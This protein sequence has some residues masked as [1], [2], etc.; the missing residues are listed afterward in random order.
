MLALAGVCACG[1]VGFD[2]DTLAGPRLIEVLVDPVAKSDDPSL[3]GDLLELYFESERAGG[4]GGGD[5]WVS[6]RASPGAPWEPPSNVVELNTA[7]LE[8]TPKVSADGLRLWLSSDRPGTVGATDIFVSTRSSRTAPWGAPVH[9]PELSSTASD[10]SPSVSGDGLVIVFTSNRS[11]QTGFD[12][13]TSKRAQA[14]VPFAS[15][16]P[17]AELN[18]A[19]P[20]DA[21]PFLEPS[22]LFLWFNS[23]RPGGREPDIFMT[24][25]ASIAEPFAVPVPVPALMSEYREV[26]SCINLAAGYAVFASDRTGKLEIWEMPWP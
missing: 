12:L 13:Y 16:T 9:V 26:D 21:G 23:N 8:S 11:G 1:R 22:G 10:G 6:R 19:G 18:T 3:T 4:A 25:R 2:E 7:A 20:D 15:P 5:I 24:K 14:D 17:L